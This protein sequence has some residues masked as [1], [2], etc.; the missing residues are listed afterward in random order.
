MQN[1]RGRH[2]DI[3]DGKKLKITE[4]GDTYWHDVFNEFRAILLTGSKFSPIK[5]GQI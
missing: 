1:S 5:R 3:T 2:V 4:R